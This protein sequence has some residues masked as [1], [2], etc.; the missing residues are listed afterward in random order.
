MK[1]IVESSM[2]SLADRG[3]NLNEFRAAEVRLVGNMCSSPLTRSI[4]CTLPAGSLLSWSADSRRALV[5]LSEKLFDPIDIALWRRVLPFARTPN[6][7]SGVLD[8][9]RAF[10]LRDA[11][12]HRQMHLF[13]TEDSVGWAKFSEHQFTRGLQYFLDGNHKV[14]RVSALLR[15][16]GARGFAEVL[17]EVDDKNDIKVSAEAPTS[18][19]KRIDLLIEWKD[20][21]NNCHAV[22]I[23]AKL[24]H[25]VTREQ[26]KSY[27][28]HLRKISKRRRLLI[29]VS[30]RRT[31]D[32]DESL[33][34]YEREWHWMAWRD[35][36]VG[37]ERSLPDR[38]DDKP[39][40]QFRRTLW[41]QTE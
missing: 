37:H 24:G 11:G 8:V 12:Q 13:Q 18:N 22:A 5:F 9:E 26:L 4:R 21:T 36:L 28:T 38:F 2:V 15:A 19:G 33:K 30:P 32:I 16:L 27:R 20:S 40:R 3:W 14:E 6:W 1:Q 10:G 35:L 25:S 7:S 23:E 34:G 39:Y 41:D 17:K 29:V 31:S